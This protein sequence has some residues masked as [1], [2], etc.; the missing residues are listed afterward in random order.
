MSPLPPI[1]WLTPFRFYQIWHELVNKCP[2]EWNVGLSLFSRKTEKCI[3]LDRPYHPSACCAMPIP[4]TA[5]GIRFRRLDSVYLSGKGHDKR[6]AHIL[7]SFVRGIGVIG[8]IGSI[9][10]IQQR[11]PGDSTW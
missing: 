6:G 8:H 10:T 2:H 1:A 4:P 3:V 11:S 9:Y 5:K 7:V